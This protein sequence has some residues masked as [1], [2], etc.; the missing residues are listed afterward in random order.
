M[1]GQSFNQKYQQIENCDV[2]YYYDNDSD[3]VEYEDNETCNE[4][5]MLDAY[6][7][8]REFN[9]LPINTNNNLEIDFNNHSNNMLSLSNNHSAVVVN[10][11][12][13]NN[14][15]NNINIITNQISINNIVSNNLIST[16]VSNNPINTQRNITN[17]L[18]TSGLDHYS[19][20]LEGN[21]EYSESNNNNRNFE[22]QLDDIFDQLTYAISTEKQNIKNQKTNLANEKMK[23]NDFKTSE[24][25]KFDKEKDI[26]KE[27]NRIIESF[28]A[29]ETDILDLDIGGTQKITT[30][31][32]TL[33]KVG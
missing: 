20:E 18:D 13:S 7:G 21:E 32:S 17:I 11:N 12:T 30:T 24:K 1:S 29:K 15:T 9:E 19:S 5:I 2:K 33:L 4:L 16:N 3:N 23:L 8:G 26:W 27:N 22:T 28:K 6:Y 10:N 25:S 14:N 31:R